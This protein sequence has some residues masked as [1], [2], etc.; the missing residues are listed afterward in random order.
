[1]VEDLGFLLAMN[2][3]CLRLRHQARRLRLVKKWV[4][5]RAGNWTNGTEE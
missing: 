3:P 4:H 1:M 2:E 5:K